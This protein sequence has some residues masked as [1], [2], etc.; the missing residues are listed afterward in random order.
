MNY[1]SVKTDMTSWLKLTSVIF[2]ELQ[3]HAEEAWRFSWITAQ[4]HELQYHA[5]EVG[6]WGWGVVLL[7]LRDWL[8]IS[9]WMPNSCTVHHLCCIFF[10]NYSYFPFFFALSNCLYLYFF[11]DS[12]F[13]PSREAREWLWGIYLVFI[14]WAKPQQIKMSLLT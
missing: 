3:C 8:G 1:Y 4:F 14:C 11:Y 6:W 5:G 2:H 9:W 13:H 7:L 12:L 10:Y